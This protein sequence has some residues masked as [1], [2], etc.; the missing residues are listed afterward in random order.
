MGAGKS[1]VGQ[2]LESLTGWRYLDN[3][4][5]VREA[6]GLV[7]PEVLA[8]GDEVALRLIERAALDQALAAEPPVI[9]SVAAGV[10][11]D[12]EDRRRMREA[13]FVVYLHASVAELTERV[14][15]G[16]GRPWLVSNAG[17]VL[18]RM[19]QERERLF[20]DTAHLVLNVDGLTPEQLASLIVR[21]VNGEVSPCP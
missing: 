20:R 11:L 16:A 1:T 7:T 10:I 3:D 18:E 4:E 14:G 8:S 17:E 19:Y 5:L 13:A 6:T 12:A 2:V 21:A 15:T 9:A